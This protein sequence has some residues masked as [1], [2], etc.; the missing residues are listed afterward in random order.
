MS[1]ISMKGFVRKSFFSTNT[2][3]TNIVIPRGESSV[4]RLFYQP[5]SKRFSFRVAN[6]MSKF[7]DNVYVNEIVL[8]SRRFYKITSKISKKEC[9]FNSSFIKTFDNISKLIIQEMFNSKPNHDNIALYEIIQECLIE[10]QINFRLDLNIDHWYVRDLD[11]KLPEN[12]YAKRERLFDSENWSSRLE[13]NC[14]SKTAE[15]IWENCKSNIINCMTSNDNEN[16][17]EYLMRNYDSNKDNELLHSSDKTFI[18]FRHLV[19][20]Q[21]ETI[22]YE[23]DKGV[24][25]DHYNNKKVDLLNA[26]YSLH[27]ERM[28]MET[29]DIKYLDYSNS[30]HYGKYFSNFKKMMK[31]YY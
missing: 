7:V 28:G 20:Q 11:H 15:T 13:R 22:R 3:K 16:S 12:F 31:E 27:K 4:T 14:R 25:S 21:K 17:Y 23:L 30:D 29:E 1:T 19:L 6:C 8:D 5:S 9:M 2:I 10:N 18:K 24:I 26:R